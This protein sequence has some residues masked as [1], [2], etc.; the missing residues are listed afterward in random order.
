[1]HCSYMQE[2]AALSKPRY[3]HSTTAFSLGPGF[4]EV[5]MFGGSAEPLIG[6][7][8]KQPKL[9]NTTLLQFSELLHVNVDVL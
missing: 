6:S 7:D 5:T 8:E 9:A 1:M 4:T 3:D 2:S